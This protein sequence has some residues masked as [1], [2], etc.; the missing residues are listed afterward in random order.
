MKRTKPEIRV[1]AR[2]W[3]FEQW[4]GEFYPDDLPEDWRFSFYSNEFYAVLVPAGYLAR[5]SPDDWQEWIEDTSKDF[6]FY[7][8][9]SENDAWQDVEVYLSLFS[10]KLKGVVLS[11]EKLNSVDSLASLVNKVKLVCPV[12]LRRVGNTISDD[13]MA[14]LQSCYEVNECWDGSSDAPSWSYNE[15]L[16]IVLRDSEEENSPEQLRQVVEKG[17][18]YAGR[19]EAIALFFNGGT[20]R[21]SDLRNTRTISELIV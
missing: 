6:C 2:G 7:L 15:S 21:I 8:E 12:S 3:D 10:E 18:E 20:P 17:L 5:Y 19:R 13:D 4:N 1:G 14:T 16:A 11:I 9:L